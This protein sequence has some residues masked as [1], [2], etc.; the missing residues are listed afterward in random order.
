[1]V[2]TAIFCTVGVQAQTEKGDMAAGGNLSIG[3]GDSY[4]NFGL[5]AKFQ[6]NVIDNLRLEPTVNYYFKKDYTSMW[7]LGVNA[8]YL[9]SVGDKLNFYPI[10]GLGVMGAKLSYDDGYG[11]EYKDSATKF[12]VNL[13]AGAEYMLTSNVSVNFE[14]KYRICSDMNRSLLTLGVAYHF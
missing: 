6:Y 2:M 5:G 11:N 10:V 4:T 9:F 13:G 8:H 12:M 3:F 1:M 7:D 14:Y